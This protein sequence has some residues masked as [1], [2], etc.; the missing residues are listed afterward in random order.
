MHNLYEVVHFL[1]FLLEFVFEDQN[2]GFATIVLGDL[3]N[4]SLVL[5]RESLQVVDYQYTRI[6]SVDYSYYAVY[7][8]K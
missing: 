6:V 8:H 3:V 7:N 1:S 2:A 4:A 5:F